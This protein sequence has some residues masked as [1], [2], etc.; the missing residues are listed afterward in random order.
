MKC[1]KI[2][3]Y[4]QI[5]NNLKKNGPFSLAQKNYYSKKVITLVGVT[6]SIS[7]T[8][9]N[10]FVRDQKFLYPKMGYK[11]KSYTHSLAEISLLPDVNPKHMSS[12]LMFSQVFMY[13]QTKT[14]MPFWQIINS[15]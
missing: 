11:G 3:Q 1:K 13:I 7:A 14:K 5:K 10:F 9:T 6:F 4:I 2:T 15:L 12:N 8:K